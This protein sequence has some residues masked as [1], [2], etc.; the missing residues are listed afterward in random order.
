ML[1]RPMSLAVV[2]GKKLL[3]QVVEVLVR[4]ENK[5]TTALLKAWDDAKD[6]WLVELV[7]VLPEVVGRLE[8]VEQFQERLK[9]RTESPEFQRLLDNVSFEASREAIEERRRMLAHVGAGIFDVTM[10]IAEAARCERVIREVDPADIFAL[11]RVNGSQEVLA[12]SHPE[13]LEILIAVG[14]VAAV[15]GGMPA[16]DHEQTVRYEMTRTGSLVLRLVTTYEAP[17]TG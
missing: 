8:Q 6:E 5:N 11:R 16:L 3:A 1:G 15:P 9:L 17:T 4:Y 14:C 13:D 10:T 12:G 7:R 2:A